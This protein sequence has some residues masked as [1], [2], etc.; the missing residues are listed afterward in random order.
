MKISA[1]LTLGLMAWDR[2]DRDTA[3]KRYTEVLQLAKTRPAFHFTNHEA[4]HLDLCVQYDL[5]EIHKN[6][7][8]LAETDMTLVE[9]RKRD[10]MGTQDDKLIMDHVEEGPVESRWNIDAPEGLGHERCA[11]S[12]HAQ[13]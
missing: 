1:G 10:F 9:S 8:I 11:S 3:T 5:L 12:K 4:Q 2:G 13:C 7:A 6:L